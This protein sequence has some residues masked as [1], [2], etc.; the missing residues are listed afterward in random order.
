MERAEQQSPEPGEARLLCFLLLPRTD[1]VLNQL[2]N[3]LLKDQEE[4]PKEAKTRV[5]LKQLRRKQ[6]P[7]V[8]SDLEAGP[9]NGLNKWFKRS[10]LR[11]RLKKRPHK[12]LQKKTRRSHHAISTSSAVGSFEGRRHCLDH[13]LSIAMVFPLLPGGKKK[14]T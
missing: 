2:V 12:S 10:L 14:I 7:L 4:D 11:K 1:I 8:K 6:K 9:E 3:H 5:P 13:L